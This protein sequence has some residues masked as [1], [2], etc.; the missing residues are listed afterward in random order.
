MAES[1]F[2]FEY[3]EETPAIDLISYSPTQSIENLEAIYESILQE[4]ER[5]DQMA[6]PER[7]EFYSACINLFADLNQ[8]EVEYDQQKQRGALF[9]VLDDDNFVDIS[10]DLIDMMDV[11]EG[12][13]DEIQL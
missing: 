2:D 1:G 12:I 10:A 4:Y 6:G 5:L 8:F 3:D 11:L 13:M 9:R 7:S